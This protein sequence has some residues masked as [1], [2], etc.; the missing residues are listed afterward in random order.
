MSDARFKTMRHIETV[1]N[2]LGTVIKELM[3]RGERHDQSKLESPEVEIFN[4]FTP[5]LRTTEYGGDEYRECLATMGEGLKHHYENNRHHPEFFQTFRC[6][7]CG[8]ISDLWSETRC[9][10]CNTHS[11]VTSIT[12]VSFMNL[13][14]IM[15]MV[16]DWLAATHRHDTGDIM[17]SL[18]KNQERF[19]YS[20]ELKQ[21]FLN[22][23]KYL[24]VS[25][26]FH[27]AEES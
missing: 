27:K 16:C 17:V 14:D 10:K 20:D 1:R 23:V 2:Y 8:N 11:T 25:K 19:G 21:I 13:I 18:E 26:T 7:N 3:F 9:T 22:T 12:S 15:E 4:E 5:K 6:D 24:D